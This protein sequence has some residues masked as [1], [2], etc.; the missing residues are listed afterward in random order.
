MTDF[1][2]VDASHMWIM[3]HDETIRQVRHFLE[4]GRFAHADEPPAGRSDES[5]VLP[6]FV[7]PSQS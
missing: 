1:I 4:H 5:V 2:T 3:E 6:P 7:P